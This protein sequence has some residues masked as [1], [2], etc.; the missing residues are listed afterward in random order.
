MK[1]NGRK[2]KAPK[3]GQTALDN[4][5]PIGNNTT[6]RVGISNGEFVVLDEITKGVFHGHVRSWD[7]LSSKMK[8]ELI[9]AGMV[10]K[11][12]KIIK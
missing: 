10:N 2:N 7:E 1:D 4:S 5:I 11:K 6:R 12:G 3:D 8:A 9:K